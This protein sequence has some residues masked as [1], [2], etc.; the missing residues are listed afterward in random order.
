MPLATVLISQRF[1][2][3]W[4]EPVGM[5]FTLCGGIERSVVAIVSKVM[6][7]VLLLLTI[8]V[9]FVIYDM[10]QAKRMATDACTRATQGMLLE[11]FLP[12]FHEKDYLITKRDKYIMIV[13]KRGM[14][15]NHCIVA[16]DGRRITGS[17]AGF[18]D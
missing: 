16:H 14:G 15:R 4:E 9:I 13:P 11:D 2:H 8:L 18:N 6:C 3:Q 12:Q 17:K 10:S 5:T 1:L 7:V